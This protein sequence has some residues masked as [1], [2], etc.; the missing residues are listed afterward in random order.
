MRLDGQTIRKI[1]GGGLT[2]RQKGGGVAK[3]KKRGCHHAVPNV[4]GTV[5]NAYTKGG[6]RTGPTT[7]GKSPC[8]VEKGG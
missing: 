1:T 5:K 7:P 4:I 6:R 3:K 8:L 2:E